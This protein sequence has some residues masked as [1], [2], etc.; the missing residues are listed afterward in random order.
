MDDTWAVTIILAYCNGP[1]LSWCWPS[2]LSLIHSPC[3]PSIQKRHVSTVMHAEFGNF[4]VISTFDTTNQLQNAKIRQKIPSSATILSG[5]HVN[6]G[7]RVYTNEYSIHAWQAAN[8]TC[9]GAVWCCE[10]IVLI[11]YRRSCLVLQNLCRQNGST[12]DAKVP[13][14]WNSQSSNGRCK[15]S[16]TPHLS[17]ILPMVEV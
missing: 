5:V 11:C 3:H 13:P 1:S 7:M 9:M 15:P 6:S 8:L 10:H 2:K 4:Y 17:P 16:T 14:S 12:S